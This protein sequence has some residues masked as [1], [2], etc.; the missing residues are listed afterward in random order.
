MYYEFVSML[1]SHGIENNFP[2]IYIFSSYNV[3]Y[4]SRPIFYHPANVR[5]TQLTVAHLPRT[6]FPIQFASRVVSVSGA[7]FRPV[8]LPFQFCYGYQYGSKVF[9]SI[10]FEK[11]K[12]YFHLKCTCL[13]KE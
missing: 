11:K 12:Q 7:T 3:N 13:F 4:F 6:E 8:L 5:I 9:I 10:I 2:Y 1:I